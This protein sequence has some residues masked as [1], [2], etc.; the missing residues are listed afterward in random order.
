MQHKGDVR[1]IYSKQVSSKQVVLAL[2]TVSTMT[3]LAIPTVHAAHDENLKN[4]TVNS[5]VVSAKA[6]HDK[7]GNTI[8]EQSYYR[9][10]GDVKV[11]TRE[12]IEK[13]HFLDVSD[14]IKRIPG[15]S[16]LNPG[17]RG[18]EYGAQQYE[19]GI[20]INGDSRVI[21]LIDGRRVDNL[22]STRSGEDSTTNFGGRS[23]GVDIDQLISMSAIDKIEVIKGPGASV[24]GPDAAGGVVNIITRKGS[25]THETNIDVSTGSWR[26]HNYTLT[27]SGSSDK[28]QSL[29]YFLTMNRVMSHNTHFKDG[30]TGQIGT[31]GGSNYKEQAVNARIDKQLG[32]KQA[33]KIWYNYKAGHDGYPIATPRLKYWNED[34]WY[35]TWFAWRI[36]E[37]D[38]NNKWKRSTPGQPG[39]NTIPGYRN[40]YALDG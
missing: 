33:L 1:M 24:Y 26:K 18:G 25:N 16:F 34:D 22:V 37:L 2:L 7:F 12:E 15:V 9:T 10:G 21:I 17:F 14:A 39:D 11:I 4:Y 35:R 20:L 5:V 31:L 36:G 27:L 3:T 32:P 38:S 6:T 40:V 28:D 30:E 8:T 23:T 13:R 29:R 19:H